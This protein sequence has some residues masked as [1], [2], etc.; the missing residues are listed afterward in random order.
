VKRTLIQSP[1]LRNRPGFFFFAEFVND[2]LTDNF[3]KNILNGKY[4]NNALVLVAGDEI[5][6][7]ML[8]LVE[9]I[10]D[11]VYGIFNVI[12]KTMDR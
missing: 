10:R 12:S 5:I 1:S 11:A 4:T 8:K 9:R 7:N 3:L 2:L 6:H